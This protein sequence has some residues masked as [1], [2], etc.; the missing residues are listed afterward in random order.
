MSNA[1]SPLGNC[2]VRSSIRSETDKR[3]IFVRAIRN[4]RQL[5]ERYI[6]AANFEESRSNLDRSARHIAK[7]RRGLEKQEKEKRKEQVLSQM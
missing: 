7:S 5:A 6:Y 3:I 1:S 2:K 4:Q